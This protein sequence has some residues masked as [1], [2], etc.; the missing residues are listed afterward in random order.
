MTTIYQALYCP[1]IHESGYITL[2]LHK[3]KEGAEQAIE[4]H[5][6][7]IKEEWIDWGNNLCDKSDPDGIGRYDSFS[8]FEKSFPFGRWENWTI[9]ESNLL[10]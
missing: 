9:S 6:Q 4:N 8:E 2:S 5:K 3:T 1:M 7:S 10:D